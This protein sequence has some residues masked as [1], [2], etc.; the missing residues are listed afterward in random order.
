ML[1]YS[2]IA[3]NPLQPSGHYMYHQ[4][5]INQ[6]YVLPTQYIY[7]FC[8]DIRTNSNYFTIQHWLTGFCN[9]DGECLLRGTGWIF[10]YNSG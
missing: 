5:N 8:V 1:L 2:L 4:F 10:N 3:V 7:V 9:L 6:F